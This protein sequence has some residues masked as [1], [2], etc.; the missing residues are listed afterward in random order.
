[1]CCKCKTHLKFKTLNRTKECRIFINYFTNCLLKQYF[2][3]LNVGLK[4]TIKI[5]F[6]ASPYF[7]SVAIRKSEILYVAGVTCLWT[8]LLGTGMGNMDGHLPLTRE[9]LQQALRPGS[10]T[11]GLQW[12]PE[13]PAPAPGPGGGASPQDPSDF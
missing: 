11:Q 9:R 10:L 7:S 3:Y 8:E 13:L 12:R 4:Y 1:M 5:N 2:R 6:T